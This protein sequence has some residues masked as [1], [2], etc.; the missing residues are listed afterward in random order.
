MADPAHWIDPEYTAAGALL[1]E[2]GLNSLTPVTSS[3]ADCR[4]MFDRIGAFLNEHSI[5]L[6]QERDICVPGPHGAIPCRLYHP[7]DIERPPLIVYAHGGSF[8]LGGLSA[9]DG[10]LRDLVRQSH[11]AVLSVDYRL[12]PEHRFPVAYDELR[13]VVR[14]V[15]NEG[16]KLKVDPSRL[17]AGGDSAGANL[18]LGA[19]LG[20]RDGGDSPLTFLLL[21][22]GVYSTEID[23]DAWRT[24]GT[25]AYG[26]SGTQMRWIYEN[27][28]SNPDQL[29][30]WRVAPLLAD[31]YRMPPMHL[32]VGTLDPLQDDNHALA[33]RLAQAGIAY[34]LAICK[35][36]PHGFIRYGALVDRARRAVSECARALAKA[37]T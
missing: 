29:T 30:D 33:A 37:L 2:R 31:M 22:Y 14:F 16:A 17:A 27:Y 3:L 7:D 5:A 26:L 6:Q 34:E 8:A 19:A 36:L 32:T 10:M 1:R 24:F 28:L 20:L 4:S 18:A 13:A 9:W 15:V 21:I 12:A 25:G 35:G 11:T 23:T